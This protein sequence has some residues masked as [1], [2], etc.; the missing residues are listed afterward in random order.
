MVYTLASLLAMAHAVEPQVSLG[1]KMRA[2]E[3]VVVAEVTSTEPRWA[4]GPRGGIE[5]VVWLAVE[6]TLA[7]EPEHS[8]EVVVPGGRIGQ[9]ATGSSAAAELAVDGRYLVLLSRDD[10]GL[11]R[12]F[13][14]SAA[15]RLQS[16]TAPRAPTL[17]D[18]APEFEVKDVE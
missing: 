14:P 17:A 16:E 4:E 12:V 8:L 2:A 18:L 10:A 9:H 3:L 5:T 7:G 1:Q 6:T 11:W 15:I 13:A